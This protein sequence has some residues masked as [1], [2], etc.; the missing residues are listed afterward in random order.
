MST[1]VNPLSQLIGS[2]GDVWKSLRKYIDRDTAKLVFVT[3]TVLVIF[4]TLLVSLL[5]ALVVLHSFLS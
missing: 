4:E 1:L 5:I 3:L 2:I